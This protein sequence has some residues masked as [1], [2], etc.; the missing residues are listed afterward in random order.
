M[1][2]QS[3]LE[4]RELG[5]SSATVRNEMA[6][7]EEAGYITHP[8][9][10]AGS[11]PSDKGYRYHVES[12]GD[13]RLSP[14]EQLQVSHQFHQVEREISEWLNLAAALIAR[15]AQNATVVTVPKPE[16]CQF[17]HLE[18]VSLR[19][20]SGLI[21]LVLEGAQVRE[22]LITFQQPVLQPELTA[23][24][25]RMSAEYST[26]TAAQIKAKSNVLAGIEQKVND[27]IV[28]LMETEDSQEVEEIYFDGL[29]FTLNQP[30]FVRD[31][32]LALDL[33]ELVE[34]R[35]LPA[36]IVPLE[37]AS[38][39]VQVIIGG[40]NKTEAIRN[41]SIVIARYGSPEEATGTIS[42]IGPTR[43]PYAR[44]MAAVSYLGTVLSILMARLYGREGTAGQG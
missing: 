29:H 39:K 38:H 5:V 23:I 13:A 15:M 37:P 21:I 9:T 1:S 26:L 36:D 16:A 27:R 40:E 2:S 14:A 30:E 19:E 3:L 18:L 6:F 31:H 17:K 28:E 20:R 33:T 24:A 25:S 32:R 10:S 42:V 41:Y 8:H 11:V 34:E 22:E 7:L 43:M 35:R 4:D 44:T 12:I